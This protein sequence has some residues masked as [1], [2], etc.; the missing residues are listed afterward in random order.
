MGGSIGEIRPQVTIKLDNDIFIVIDCTHIKQ[1][2]RRASCMARVQNMRT[3]RTL[4]LTLR[5]SDNFDMISVEKRTLQYSYH[6]GDHY[7]FLLTDTYED[8]V[9]DKTRIEEQIPWLKDNSLINGLFLNDE[10]LSL[11]LPLSLILKVAETEP[12]YKGDTVKA[13][14]K[15]AKLE[16]GVTVQVPLFINAG[17]TIKVDTRTKNYIE[18]I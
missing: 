7:H 14:Y 11:E 13:G 8:M 16:T 2:N 10:L 4:D 9:L 1:A 17:E 3:G 12:G 5:D 6:D 15:P 18:R